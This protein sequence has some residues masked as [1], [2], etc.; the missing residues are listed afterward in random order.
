MPILSASTLATDYLSGVSSSDA[1]TLAVLGRALARAEDRA[2]AYLGYPGAAPTLAQQT[3]TIRT[4]GRRSS[5]RRLPLRVAP[6][7][8]ITSVHQDEDHAFAASTEVTSAQYELETLAN[9]ALLHLLPTSTVSSWYTA[10]RSVRVVC[11]AGY[12]NEAAMPTRLPDALYRWVADWWMRR[13][14]RHLRSQAVSG[15]VVNQGIADLEDMPPD[16]A[17]ALAELKLLGTVGAW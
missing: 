12:A 6:V 14:I 11:V 7:A 9:G 5:P 8:S 4:Q 16:I 15:G 10:D 13:Q 1:G 3:Y 17:Q 2:A